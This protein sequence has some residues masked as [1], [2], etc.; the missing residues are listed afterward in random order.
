MLT[1][2]WTFKDDDRIFNA[3]DYLVTLRLLRKCIESGK[4][5]FNQMELLLS[6]L[7]STSLCLTFLN[8]RRR[9][10]E[11]DSSI[12]SSVYQFVRWEFSYFYQQTL[13]SCLD[14]FQNFYETVIFFSR[15][16]FRWSLLNP[17]WFYL[18]NWPFWE[19]LNIRSI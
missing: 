2:I 19:C 7:M 15:N 17:Y 3:K 10:V 14:F 8:W 4:T 18:T 16:Y 1:H 11:N 13:S 5:C 12:K 9:R 6:F